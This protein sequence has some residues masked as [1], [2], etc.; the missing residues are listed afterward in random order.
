M[1]IN[2]MIDTYN[3][4]EIIYFILFC[5][6]FSGF[7][8]LVHYTRTSKLIK[9][10]SKIIVGSSTVLSGIDA[11]SNLSNKYKGS[12]NNSNSNDNSKDDKSKDDKSKD[13]KSKDKS[14]DDSS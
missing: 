2:Y 6:S 13:D 11:A 1:K 12:N 4:Y 14:N 9:D 7:I 8:V 10:L 3:M 5:T